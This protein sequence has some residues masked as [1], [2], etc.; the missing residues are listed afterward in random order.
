MFTLQMYDRRQGAV[1]PESAGG[2]AQEAFFN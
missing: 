2:E 1:M